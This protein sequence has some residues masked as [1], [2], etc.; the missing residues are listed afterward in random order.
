MKEL[1]HSKA[2]VSFEKFVST[3]ITTSYMDSS[4]YMDFYYGIYV[5]GPPEAATSRFLFQVNIFCL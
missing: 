2:I 1:S 4:L 3:W 5:L